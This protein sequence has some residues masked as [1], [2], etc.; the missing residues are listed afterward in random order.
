MR[1]NR[2]CDRSPEDLVQR[3]FNNKFVIVGRLSDIPTVLELGL[4]ATFCLII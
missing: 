3:V 2:V 4:V 1:A